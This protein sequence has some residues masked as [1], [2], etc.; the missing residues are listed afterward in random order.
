MGKAYAMF[1]RVFAAAK[2][3]EGKLESS[4]GDDPSHDARKDWCLGKQG[5]CGQVCLGRRGESLSRRECFFGILEKYMCWPKPSLPRRSLARPSDQDN[6][7]Q[8]GLCTS[9]A[10]NCGIPAP[11]TGPPPTRTDLPQTAL[12]RNATRRT[13]QNCRQIH[14]TRDFFSTLSSLCT[15]PI[16]AQGVARRVC[17][18]TCSCTCHHMLER[19]LFPC[20]VFFLSLPCLYVLSH[21]YLF[22]VLLFNFHVVKTAEH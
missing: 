14:L 18:K 22:S 13:A 15:H 20:F 10:P 8:T 17:I 7:D 21:F 5:A 9:C 12:R 11:A 16:V 19:L 2:T 4:W 6:F 1:Y 3:D